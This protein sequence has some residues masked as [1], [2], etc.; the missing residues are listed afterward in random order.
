MTLQERI[1]S[2]LDGDRY[3]VVGASQDRNKYGNKVLRCYMQ[4]ERTQIEKTTAQSEESHNHNQE[5]RK[6]DTDRDEGSQ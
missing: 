4:N 5:V 2:F 1:D 6:D 3:A